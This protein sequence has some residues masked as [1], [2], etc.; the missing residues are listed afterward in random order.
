MVHV[1][2]F[3]NYWSDDGLF[4]PKLVTN[5]WNNKIKDSCDREHNLSHF[6]T[7][8]DVLY[9]EQIHSLYYLQLLS[10]H[11]LLGHLPLQQHSTKEISRIIKNTECEVWSD[12]NSLQNKVVPPYPRVT[13]SKTYHGYVKP[14]IIPN[15]IYNVIF[16]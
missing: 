10:L 4:R 5:I 8:R 14:R 7:Q 3:Y 13:C 1:I 11:L 2:S 9:Q 15:A 16:V 6:N 12:Y